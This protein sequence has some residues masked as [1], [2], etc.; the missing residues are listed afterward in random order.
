MTTKTEIA[1]TIS[2]S[3][4]KT[5]AKYLGPCV[6]AALVWLALSIYMLWV[7]PAQ[8]DIREQLLKPKQL[9]AALPAPLQAALFIHSVYGTA[10][11][12]MLGLLGCGLAYARR[13]AKL[14][15]LMILLG[16]VCLGALVWT[17]LVSLPKA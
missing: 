13:N 16:A 14:A 10:I 17:V 12:S 11:I 2:T 6:V 3:P 7:V 1:P 8:L 9:Q 5:G 4:A 15:N